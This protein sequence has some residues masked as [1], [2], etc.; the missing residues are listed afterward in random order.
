MAKSQGLKTKLK[1]TCRL[2][3]FVVRI[4]TVAVGCFGLQ[5]FGAAE[6]AEN[7]CI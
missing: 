3:E 4:V 7:A 6:A 2:A 5:S 1:K